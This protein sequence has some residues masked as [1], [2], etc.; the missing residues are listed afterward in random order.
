MDPSVEDVDGAIVLK[1][2]NFLVEDGGNKISVSG[3]HNFIYEFYET[4]GEGH[5]SSRVNIVIELSTV[6][7]PAPPATGNDILLD[8]Y[9]NILM[10]YVVSD[11]I[12]SLVLMMGH[13]CK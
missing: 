12:L 6:D 8:S 13:Y 10:Q 11:T 7:V 2:N 5:G 4:V 3:T 9:G 1:F